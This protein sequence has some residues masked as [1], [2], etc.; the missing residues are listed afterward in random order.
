MTKETVTKYPEFCAIV[1]SILLSFPNSYIVKSGFSHVHLFNKQTKKH[2]NIKC[3]DS[4]FKLTNLLP[5][6]R[7]LL[8]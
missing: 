8:S 3:G 6:I 1:E 5:N 4:W 7:D 2:L